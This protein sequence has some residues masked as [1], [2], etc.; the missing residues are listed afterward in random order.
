MDMIFWVPMLFHSFNWLTVTPYFLL[1]ANS[2]S[3]VA[4]VCEILVDEEI[5]VF[6]VELVTAGWVLVGTGV[7]VTTAGLAGAV[8]DIF[9]TGISSPRFL[10]SWRLR[11]IPAFKSLSFLI[12]FLD[13]NAASLIPYFWEMLQSVS[14][15]RTMWVATSTH[16]RSFSRYNNI[17]QLRFA[18]L[19]PS[20]WV[21][22]AC[23][24]WSQLGWR[25]YPE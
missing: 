7:V 23:S 1:I 3:P 22:S 14:P 24:L 21:F 4:T 18:L 13:F 16:L 10:C 5:V 19:G 8:F 6:L 15:G 2:V 17:P 20:H 11:T 9:T 25:K 12:L